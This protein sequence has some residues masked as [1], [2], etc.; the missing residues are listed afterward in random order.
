MIIRC[1]AW[2]LGGGAPGGVLASGCIHVVI[3]PG[4]L[5]RRPCDIL[6]VGWRTGPGAVKA[7]AGPGYMTCGG[8]VW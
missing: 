1:G 7:L 3:S 5:G 2:A 4:F 8:C 6:V